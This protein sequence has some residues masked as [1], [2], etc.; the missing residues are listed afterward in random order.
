MNLHLDKKIIVVTDGAKGI[1]EGIVKALAA[2]SAVLVIVGRNETDNLKTLESIGNKGFQVVCE[3]TKP[4]ECEYA[5]KKI[6]EKYNRIDG[7]IKNQK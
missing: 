1:G 3:L 7:L 5:T 4:E 6:I 2:E